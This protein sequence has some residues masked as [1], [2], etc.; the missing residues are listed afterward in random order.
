MSSSTHF[1]KKKDKT[2]S[3][4]QQYNIFNEELNIYRTIIICNDSNS[5]NDIYNILINNDYSPYIADNDFPE[6]LRRNL[7]IYLMSIDEYLNYSS[8]EIRT[9]SGEHNMLVTYNLDNTHTD[10][11]VKNIIN[12]RD[13]ND[14][15]SEYYIWIN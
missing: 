13:V 7:R 4:I 6:F 14:I 9:I 1:L 8:D 10:I 11:V 12:T 5:K 3:F 2:V 15:M